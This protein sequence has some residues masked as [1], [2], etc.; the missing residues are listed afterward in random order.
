[1]NAYHSSWLVVLSCGSLVSLQLQMCACEVLRKDK[2][3]TK[4]K[5]N[6]KKTQNTYVTDYEHH[7]AILQVSQ[8]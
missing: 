7:V 2:K 5:Q 6:K 3:K 4:K 8:S 1:M